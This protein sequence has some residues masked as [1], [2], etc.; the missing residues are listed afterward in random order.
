M[1]DRA[2]P[3]TLRFEYRQAKTGSLVKAIEQTVDQPKSRNTTEFQVV[4][5]AYA[6][7]GKV[8]A[9]RVLLK[10]GKETLTVRESYLWQ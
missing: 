10:R 9:W 7:D 1:A 5:P 4:G 6:Q 2:T 8:L 3:V